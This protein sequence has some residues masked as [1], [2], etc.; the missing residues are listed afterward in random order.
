MYVQQGEGN[1][2]FS[3]MSQGKGK[4]GCNFDDTPR[5]IPY[6]LSF[7]NVKQYHRKGIRPRLED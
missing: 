6:F 1:Q 5:N 7:T 2:P 3:V 4:L